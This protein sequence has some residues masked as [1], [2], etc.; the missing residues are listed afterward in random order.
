MVSRPCLFSSEREKERHWDR[1]HVTTGSLC[2]DSTIIL[3]YYAQPKDA[4]KN[5]TGMVAFWKGVEVKS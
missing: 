4:A 2:L 3:R 1:S 5:I